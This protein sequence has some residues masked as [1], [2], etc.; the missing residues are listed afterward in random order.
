[1]KP[2]PS[3][4][5]AVSHLDTAKVPLGDLVG[6]WGYLGRK[7]PLTVLCLVIQTCSSAAS[8]VPYFLRAAFLEHVLHPKTLA[9]PEAITQ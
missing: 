1:M 4:T 6:H 9:F 2:G 7:L 8:V 3:D 5:F